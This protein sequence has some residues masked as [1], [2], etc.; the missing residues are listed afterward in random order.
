MNH[1]KGTTILQQMQPYL[2]MKTLDQLIEKHR[3]DHKVQQHTTRAH[4]QVMMIAM[5]TRMRSLKH[6]ETLDHMGSWLHFFG[7]QS[8]KRATIARANN[9]RP[10]MIF[11]E[12]FYSILASAK[13]KIPRK[14]N[15]IRK[16]IL[17]FDSSTI[18]LSKVLFGWAPFK[19]RVGGIKLHT[20]FD[21]AKGI[22]EI[23]HITEAKPHD[24]TEF[25]PEKRPRKAIVLMDRAYV[26]FGKM[27]QLNRRKISFVTRAKSTMRYDIVKEL[28]VSGKQTDV[29]SDQVIKPSTQRGK[30]FRSKLRLVKYKDPKTRKIYTFMTNNLNWA[31]QTVADL[32][33][34]RWDIE[35]FFKWIKQHLKIKTFFGN[36]YNA[37][38]MQIW[39]AL[40]YYLTLALM[41]AAHKI[42]ASLHEIHT[43]LS[44]YWNCEKPL[45]EL[46]NFT[47]ERPPNLVFTQLIA[48]Q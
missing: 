2:P 26:D 34:Q 21:V 12:L 31:A 32:Y 13:Q 6:I 30:R 20:L 36:S 40:I 43:L 39:I 9:T 23:V 17:A 1:R 45:P 29:I 11:Q 19:T 22:P 8:V 5:I 38:M 27:N 28:P 7:I 25:H 3:G 16:Q 37:V 46:L 44:N 18:V 33:K 47:K 15:R 24:S 41:K 42:P 4:F 14:V 10:H 35:L 48:G